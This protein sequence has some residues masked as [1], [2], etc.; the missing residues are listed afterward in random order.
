MA[1][2]TI[3]KGAKSDISQV[4][5]LIR[6]LA[7]FEKALDSVEVT[8]AQLTEDGFGAEP[9]FEFLVASHQDQ[10]VGLSLF[11]YRYSTWKGKGLYLEDLIVTQSFRGRGIGKNLL[12]ETA[13][14]AVRKN[15]TG[16]YWQVLDWNTPAIEFYTSLGAKFDGEWINCK[17]DQETL[18]NHSKE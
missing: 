14:Y 16:M 12:K 3:R 5:L 13:E 18:K 11:Y 8:E 10:I 1:T 7:E 4:M 6:E 17:L 2:I 15:C 9:A